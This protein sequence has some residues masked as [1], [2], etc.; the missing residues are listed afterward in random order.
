LYFVTRKLSVSLRFRAPL[1][2]SSMNLATRGDFD[3]VYGTT[4]SIVSS[5]E[6]KCYQWRIHTHTMSSTVSVPNVIR[7]WIP[8]VNARNL[9]VRSLASGRCTQT[10]SSTKVRGLS[11]ATAQRL[12]SPTGIHE[13]PEDWMGLKQIT[14]QRSAR[15][16]KK[17]IPL[18]RPWHDRHRNCGQTVD[19]PTLLR[20]YPSGRCGLFLP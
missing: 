19:R 1:R 9:L 13:Q 17:I 4:G 12:C 15:K 11:K 3:L 10:S 18:R 8:C 7:R 16:T 14:K 5:T 6:I 20:L 2:V